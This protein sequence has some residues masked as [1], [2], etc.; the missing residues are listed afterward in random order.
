MEGVSILGEIMRQSW[1]MRSKNGFGIFHLGFNPDKG[2]SF[3]GQ[4][5][6]STNFP[7]SQSFSFS[8][9]LNIC[10]SSKFPDNNSQPPTPPPARASDCSPDPPSSRSKI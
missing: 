8:Q 4:A 9:I 3:F 7:Q 2:F 10:F 1:P 6:R 5:A